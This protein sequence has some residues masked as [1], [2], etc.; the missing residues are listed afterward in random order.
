[1]ALN[2][3]QQR[4]YLYTVDIWKQTDPPDDATYDLGI[5]LRS[6]YGK[7]ALSASGV[8]CQF[9]STP[10]EDSPTAIG[11]TKT[12]NIFTMDKFKFHISVDI[13]DT[14]A[15]VGVSGPNGWNEVGNVWAVQGNTQSHSTLKISQNQMVYG[16][17]CGPLAGMAGAYPALGI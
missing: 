1:M 15:I 10:E 3:R 17:I 7:Y 16:K 12:V 14:D 11:R 9:W 5:P 4:Y 8:L 13:A 2:L 6:D